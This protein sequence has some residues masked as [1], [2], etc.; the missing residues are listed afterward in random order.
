MVAYNKAIRLLLYP[1]L[2]VDQINMKYINTCVNAC[3]ELLHIH[4]RR[5]TGTAYDLNLIALTSV[6]TSGGLSLSQDQSD[7]H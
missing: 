4:Q 5:Y 2:F 1:Q 6:F 7:H 3:S